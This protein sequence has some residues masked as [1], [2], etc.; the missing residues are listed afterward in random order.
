MIALEGDFSEE[1]NEMESVFVE[2]DGK[3]VPFFFEWVK[4]S[5]PNSIIIKFEYY[6]SD[7]T[8]TEFIACPVYSD[9]EIVT[10]TSDKSCD[11]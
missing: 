11:I 10:V 7:L 5:G 3:P 6:D 2:V 4:D 9:K 1:V 8:M